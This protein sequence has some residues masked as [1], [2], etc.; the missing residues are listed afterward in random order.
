MLDLTRFPDLFS[1][2]NTGSMPAVSTPAG[3]SAPAAPA[4][5]KDI[6][7]ITSLRSNAPGSSFDRVVPR[8]PDAPVTVSDTGI[9]Q[10]ASLHYR[11]NTSLFLSSRSSQTLQGKLGKS[12]NFSF[13]SSQQSATAI[14]RTANQAGTRAMESAQLSYQGLFEAN[15]DVSGSYSE[16][17]QFQ[18]D[19]FFSRT[20]TL[21]QQLSPETGEHLA[22]TGQQVHRQFEIE[23]SLNFS[24]L[25][26]F[27]T[28]TEAISGDEPTLNNYLD[29][30]NGLSARSGEAVQAFFDEVDRLLS[31]T[32]SFV[33]D[34][35]GSFLVDVKAAFGLN[36][37]EA[38]SF[39]SLV[40][41]EVGAFFQEVG[42]FLS[43]ARNTLMAPPA[44]PQ[45]TS[46]EA[47]TAL[48]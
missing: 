5:P 34:A 3:I 27:N 16:L 31:D 12:L 42:A 40:A 28:Q 45:V 38:A 32:G 26:Q 22:S 48:V 11:Q 47:E 15:R 35:L 24:F 39:S 25:Q 17:R 6:L 23:I 18:T 4:A 8:S 41:R 2:L 46:P 37:D 1:S 36:D 20:R 43:E 29:D 9:Y 44:P 19:L 14:Q 30:V 10:A 13:N 33:Q 7:D 21:S